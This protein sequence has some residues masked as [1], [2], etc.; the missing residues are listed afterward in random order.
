MIVGIGLDIVDIARIGKACKKREGFPARVLTKKELSIYSQ[1]TSNRQN[2]FL[3]GRFAAKEAF[4]KAYGTGIG[5]IGFLD[6]EILTGELG[7][8]T[9]SKSPFEGKVFV[10]ITHTDSVAAAQVIL[11]KP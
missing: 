1:L 6:I 5:K 11:E 9:I 7:Q 10:S 2:E 8:P 3:A 4:A